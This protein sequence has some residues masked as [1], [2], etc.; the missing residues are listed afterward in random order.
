MGE[1]VIKKKNTTI[2]LFNYKPFRSVTK[3]ELSRTLM[4]DDYVDISVECA[5]P[6]DLSLGD[7]VVVEEKTF[8]LNMLPPAKKLAEDQFSYELRFEGP[9]FLL[10]KSKVFDLDSQGNKTN[11]DVPLTGEINEFLYLIINNA[12]KWDNKWVLGDFPSNT[13]TKSMQFSNENCLAALQRICQEFKVEF[14]I[15]EAGGKFTLNIREKIGKT[16]SF[17]VEYGMG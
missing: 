16:L 8:F 12:N 9:A 13:E 3:A 14:D 17:T 6:L 11:I 5:N 10:R 2:D 7:R 1:I 15:V 4:S